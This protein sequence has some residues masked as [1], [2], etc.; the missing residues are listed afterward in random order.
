MIGT[1]SA[2]RAAWSSG[3]D[4]CLERALS[5]SNPDLRSRL[6]TWLPLRA[7][8]SPVA[9]RRR[10]A[11]VLTRSTGCR[12]TRARAGTRAHRVKWWHRLTPACPRAELDR[13]LAV[14][15]GRYRPRLV[16]AGGIHCVASGAGAG[17]SE[18]ATASPQYFIPHCCPRVSRDCY[19]SA[20]CWPTGN[21]SMVAACISV[22]TELDGGPGSPDRRG[23]PCWREIPNK[24]CQL[25]FRR[26]NTGSIRWSLNGMPPDVCSGATISHGST[27]KPLLAPVMLDELERPTSEAAAHE[28]RAGV[29]GCKRCRCGSGRVAAISRHVIRSVWRSFRCRYQRTQVAARL[30]PAIYLQLALQQLQGSSTPSS[31]TKIEQDLRFTVTKG[32]CQTDR[33]RGDDGSSKTARDISLDF[34]WET[35]RATGV[36]EDKAVDVSSR[37]RAPGRHVRSRLP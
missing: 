13:R 10:F 28:C 18:F 36:A 5:D 8:R 35:G 34:N 6:E 25:A 3:H 11:A 21:A 33:Y 16:S 20:G 17:C 1:S 32:R 14:T 24:P 31:A 30:R 12:R 23:L 26:R 22:T 4:I 2:G 29:A 19:T 7:R 37:S 9:C 15:L 27:A